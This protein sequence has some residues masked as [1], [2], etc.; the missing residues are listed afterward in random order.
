MEKQFKLP[1]DF[2][3]KWLTNLRNGEYKQSKGQLYD[4][5]GY[6]CLG[7][8]CLTAGY[9]NSDMKNVTGDGYAST[10]TAYTDKDNGSKR[11]NLAKP[12]LNV[13]EELRMPSDVNSLVLKLTTM[14]DGGH[15][16]DYKS[17]EEIATWVEKNVEFY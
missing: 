17:F 12:L 3:E 8:A 13:P 4:E 9:N 15:N 11:Y 6:C 5:I 1:K 10:I 2:A 16:K 7:I 14:N